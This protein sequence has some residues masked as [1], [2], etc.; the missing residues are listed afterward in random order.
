MRGQLFAAM[1]HLAAAVIVAVP[2]AIWVAGI[3]DIMTASQDTRMG[4][5]TGIISSLSDSRLL[6][7]S[8]SSTEPVLMQ[9][10]NWC[11]T[12][13]HKGYPESVK[14]CQAMTSAIIMFISQIL[15]TTLESTVLI[16]L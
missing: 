16:L 14:F 1:T 10:L 12:K 15:Y 9:H 5:S 4:L 2:L 7:A 13:Q 3:A 6:S 11:L 8:Y